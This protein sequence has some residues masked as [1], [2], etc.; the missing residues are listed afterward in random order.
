MK[1]IERGHI[2][3]LHHLDGTGAG[4]LVFVNRETGTR[5]EGTQT[6]EVLRACVDKAQHDGAHVGEIMTALINRTQHCDSCLRWDG[7]DKIVAHLAG[8]MQAYA[9]ATKQMRM[10]LA[11]HESRAI[12]RKTEKGEIEPEKVRVAD[13]GHFVLATPE[14]EPLVFDEPKTSDYCKRCGESP[15]SASHWV[16]PDQHA[17]EDPRV[18]LV[19][20]TPPQ[21]H[22]CNVPM[23]GDSGLCD[24]C[25]K[26]GA[27]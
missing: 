10:A 12:E 25:R 6:Q 15:E 13:D 7:N 19:S 5:H 14:T 3:Q 1:V 24:E 2:Y 4:L 20:A 26:R 11:L 18:A 16:G 9:E 21:L 8:A 27:R 17:Y 22:R 23:C